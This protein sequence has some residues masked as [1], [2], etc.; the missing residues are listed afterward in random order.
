LDKVLKDVKAQA[1]L[2]SVGFSVCF[3]YKDKERK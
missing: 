2:I 3:A 1:G